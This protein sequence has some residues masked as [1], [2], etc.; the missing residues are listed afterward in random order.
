[1]SPTPT[2][3]II[4]KYYNK[5][6]LLYKSLKEII[7]S[8]INII[9]NETSY[10]INL[11]K[12]MKENNYKIWKTIRQISNETHFITDIK[13]YLYKNIYYK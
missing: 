9:N 10:Y 13:Q 5:S 3:L 4:E 12:F 1:M 6:M 7:I 2:A 11:E 8:D